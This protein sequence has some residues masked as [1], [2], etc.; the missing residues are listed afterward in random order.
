[1]NAAEHLK[2]AVQLLAGIDTNQGDHFTATG[3][4][5]IQL[6]QAHA[7]CAL[8]IE[9]G[10]P[11]AAVSVSGN[12]TPIKKAAGQSDNGGGQDQEQEATG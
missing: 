9:L 12:V 10:V 5:T 4:L 7:V 1:M 11:P 2:L 6:A 8:A 3:A